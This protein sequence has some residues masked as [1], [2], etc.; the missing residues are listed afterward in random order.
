MLDL[1]V[2]INIFD[3]LRTR[4]FQNV[5][6]DFPEKQR[7]DRGLTHSCLIH[8]MKMLDVADEPIV[9]LP[10]LLLSSKYLELD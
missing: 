7:F 2:S 3:R 10:Y 9:C 8:E 5:L 6:K 4:C 1:K